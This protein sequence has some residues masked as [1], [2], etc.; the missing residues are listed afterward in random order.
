[1]SI[2]VALDEAIEIRGKRL[3]ESG[4]YAVPS[5]ENR[6]GTGSE[7][8]VVQPEGMPRL[9]KATDLQ[10]AAQPQWIAK[11]RLPRAAVS[12][13]IGDEGIGKSL[14]WAWIAAAITT[15]KALPEFGIPVR[16]PAHII[17]VCTEDDWTTTVLPRLKIAG[18][19][20]EMVQ[21]ICTEDDGSGAPLFPRDLFLILEADPVPALIIVDC[22]LDTVPSALSVRDPQHAR[23][24]LHPWKEVATATGAGVLLLAHTN[25][26]GSPN[27]RD[28]YG[29]SYALRQKARLTLYAQQDDEGYLLI[30][31]EKA[32]STADVAAS[33]F[34]ILS[35]PFF[36]P[37]DEHDGTVPLLSYIGESD[38]TARQ[39]VAASAEVGAD[40]P[41]GN[42]AKQFIYQYLVSRSGEATAVDV[43]KEGRRAGFGDQELKDAR[44]RHRHP[45]IASRKASM[46]DGW[47]WAIDHDAAEGGNFSEGGSQDG[48][49]PTVPPSLPSPP[50]P[51]SADTDIDVTDITDVTPLFTDATETLKT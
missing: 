46:G 6:L 50:S 45:R 5:S 41:G 38:L 49:P 30:G 48:M 7:D 23:R 8:A 24:A 37:T 3:A 36:E 21:V 31:P 17:L 33:K 25:R 43:L 35:K 34:T 26:V 20:I 39:H 40:E 51:P 42:P 11:N 12:L 27:A 14:F 32:N 4:I 9:W 47:V 13:L 29:A 44:R 22:W 15:G 16:D 2:E 19:D 18:T 10:P 1:M 28:R